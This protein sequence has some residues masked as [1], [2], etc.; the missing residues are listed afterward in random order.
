MTFQPGFSRRRALGRQKRS[1]AIAQVPSP[2]GQAGRGRLQRSRR[3]GWLGGVC[4]G[5]ADY[6]GINPAWFRTAF[7]LAGFFGG[8]GLAFYI[9]AWIWLPLEPRDNAAAEDNASELRGIQIGFVIVGAVMVASLLINDGTWVGFGVVII[10]LIVAAGC[11]VLRRGSG[12]E[13]MTMLASALVLTAALAV[14]NYQPAIGHRVVRASTPM[15]LE[16]ETG[17]T[18]SSV[19]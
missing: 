13:R 15:E 11:I 12:L 7:V 3:R 8:I 9:L 5:L 1:V 18:T 17:Y 14:A 6:S 2:T 10:P 16:R 19:I 4:G